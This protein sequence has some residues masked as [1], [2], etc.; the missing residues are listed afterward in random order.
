VV[1]VMIP[2]ASDRYAAIQVA[3]R[4]GHPELAAAINQE[5]TCKD[6]GGYVSDD[7]QTV[8]PDKCCFF[9]SPA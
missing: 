1:I 8:D 7:G 9:C 3:L 5:R 6:C 2:H 4:Q